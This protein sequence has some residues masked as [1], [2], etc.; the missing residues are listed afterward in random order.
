MKEVKT[1]L[2][3]L[4]LINI[5]TSLLA[6]KDFLALSFFHDFEQLLLED[7]IK[8]DRSNINMKLLQKIYSSLHIRQELTL[9]ESEINSKLILSILTGHRSK[10]QNGNYSKKHE[11]N[12]PKSLII[13]QKA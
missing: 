1:S 12:T 6:S 9:K 4:G 2:M 8:T 7:F 10:T 13:N 5:Q 3:L 11:C